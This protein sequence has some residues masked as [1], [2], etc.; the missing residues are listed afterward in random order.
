MQFEP[1]VSLDKSI[2]SNLKQ[3]QAD[4]EFND[5]MAHTIKNGIIEYN[6]EEN[7]SAKCKMYEFKFLCKNIVYFVI[8]KI[9]HFIF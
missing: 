8:S 7:Y 1:D 2:E 5:E 6:R 3:T 4:E 9:V